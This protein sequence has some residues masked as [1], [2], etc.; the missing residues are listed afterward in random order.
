MIVTKSDH[1]PSREERLDEYLC[2]LS[3]HIERCVLGGSDPRS[4][5]VDMAVRVRAGQVAQ[6]QMI[7]RFKG[8]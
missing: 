6:V 8:K 2:N 5:M 3:N 1:S 7:N 4:L